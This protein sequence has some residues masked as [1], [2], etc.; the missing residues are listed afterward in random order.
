MQKSLKLTKEQNKLILENYDQIKKN[1]KK[2]LRKNNHLIKYNLL[3]EILSYIPDVTLEYDNDRAKR[4]K[5]PNWAASR[6]IRRWLDH[7]RKHNPNFTKSRRNRAIIRRIKKELIKAGQV[8]NSESIENYLKNA[9]IDPKEI[10][11][12]TIYIMEDHSNSLDTI[13]VFDDHTQIEWDDFKNDIIEKSQKHFNEA[14]GEWATNRNKN[15]Q[16]YKRLL[17]E[18]IIPLCDRQLS[19]NSP[20]TLSALAQDVSVKESRLSQMIRDEH[21][22][23]F[24]NTLL[25]KKYEKI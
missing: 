5:F 16:I 1:I 9:K 18:Y 25:D 7:L 11:D 23:V 17:K 19:K 8:V 22:Q 24:V 3:Y 6:S 15:C 10:I 20:E 4:I 2:F 21:M 13:Q 14:E 12:N